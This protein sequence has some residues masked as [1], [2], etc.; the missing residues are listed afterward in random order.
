MKRIL[1]SLL[2][3][4]FAI[5]LM[6]SC[7]NEGANDQTGQSSE[8]T[9]D[10]SEANFQTMTEQ[11]ADIK[12]L[13]YQIPAWD[14]LTL[15]QKELTYYLTQAG[16]AGRDMMYDQNYRHNLT[17]RRT[18][19]NVF[20]SFDGDKST[21][22]WKA[23]ETYLKRIWFANGIHHHYSYEKFTTEFDRV[24]LETLLAETGSEL[25]DEVMTVIFD[26]TIDSKKVSKDP[27][28]DLV[29][30]SAVNF[31]D[32]TLTEADVNAF[33][34]VKKKDKDPKRPISYGL[35]SKLVKENGQVMEK[36]WKVG[37]MYGPALEK[38]VYWLEKAK[39]VAETDKQKESIGYLI[40]YYQTGDLN[41]W[42]QYNIAWV[43]DTLSTVDYINGFVEVYN[44]PLGYRGSYETVVEIRDL[45]ASKKMK[46]IA[47]N[48]QYFEDNSSILDE[49][50]KENVVGISYNFI[51]VAGE[52]GDA[53]PSTPI[54]VN[55]PNADWI[56]AEYG[57]KSVS[58]GNIV[59]AY[60]KAGTSG[61]LAEFSHDSTEIALAKKYAK[62]ADKLHTALHEVIGH[63]SGKLNPGIGTPKETLKNYASTLE[64][65]RADL[66][67]LYYMLDPKL[68][69]IGVMDD[70]GVGYHA[71]DDYI[72][73]GLMTQLRRI[74]PGAVIEEDH[75]RNRQMV[76]AWVFEKGEADNVISKVMRDS[77]TYF[78][79]NDYD[80]LQ[81][82]FG[83]LLREIQRI[84]SEGD[85]EAGKALVETYGVQV[86][87]VL[88]AEVLARTEKFN[89]APY[90]GFINPQ[91]VPIME[92]GKIT[93][94]RVEYPDDFATQMLYYAD[95]FT[96]LPDYN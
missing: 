31:Y 70:L 13:R 62:Q 88:H 18:L 73:N 67:A 9:S 15:Q 36:T 56:R 24:Y 94:V 49:H 53:S 44:D 38:V 1:S 68:I 47:E 50:K 30:A 79:I 93:E 3:V 45:D 64:E 11:F 54:G 10:G 75:M 39:A 22:S 51:N 14:E 19:E 66:V 27:N 7:Q 58:L 87:P 74:E 25:S 34:E 90:G 4:V 16:T 33:Y 48:A 80:K 96:T 52:A 29:L 83:D 37:G 6:T 85:Y 20:R 77:L 17:I 40:E 2:T 63:A 82:L 21:D 81:T 35:N 8:N 59:A 78:E 28:K 46:V 95:E 76:A 42:D 86:D 60:D 41:K 65:G 61:F 72:K 55:L 69:E 23:F 12:I 43:Q 84:K 71:Y 92:D 89:S 57:S 26:P 91:L 5:T 32:P